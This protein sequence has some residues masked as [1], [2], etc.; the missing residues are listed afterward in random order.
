MLVLVP[1]ACGKKDESGAAKPAGSAAQ[2]TE[3]AEPAEPTAQPTE[4]AEPSDPRHDYTKPYLTDEK[5]AKFI[6]SMQEAQ[7]PFEVVFKQPGPVR[8][9]RDLQVKLEIANAFTR[10]YGFKDYED[11]L[12]VWARIIVGQAQIMGDEVTKS[13]KQMTAD[14]AK[15]AEEALKQPGLDPELR[16]MYEEQ[17]AEIKKQGEADQSEAAQPEA[18]LNAA[19]LALVKKYQAQIEN[20]VKK[21]RKSPDENK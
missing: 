19:D 15:K 7:H 14:A 8:S 11:Y 10:K 4:P 1:A 20:A 13:V 16:K 6:E 9:M 5:L 3:P 12:A 18:L 17:L 2:P 21:Y